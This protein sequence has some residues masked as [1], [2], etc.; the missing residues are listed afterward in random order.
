MYRHAHGSM[1]IWCI[2][3]YVY[4]VRMDVCIFGVYAILRSRKCLK[5]PSLDIVCHSTCVYRHLHRHV[6]RHI[7]MHIR[8]RIQ[9]RIRCN[10][11]KMYVQDIEMCIEKYLD[12]YMDICMDMCMT[13]V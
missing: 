8:M 6:C 7:R 11:L 3:T 4:L 12:M 2:W 5:L 10:G 13:C 1:Y 9:I